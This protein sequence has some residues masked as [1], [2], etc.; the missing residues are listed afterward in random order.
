MRAFVKCRQ[1]SRAF[2]KY[3]GYVKKDVM[4]TK[5]LSNA[6]DKDQN[7]TKFALSYKTFYFKLVR[8]LIVRN[9][10]FLRILGY[11]HKYLLKEKHMIL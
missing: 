10:T 3:V 6:R 2:L 4:F 9:P 7:F 5:N 1:T 8:K 11:F